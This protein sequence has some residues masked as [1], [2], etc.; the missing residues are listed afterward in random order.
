M[1][2]KQPFCPHYGSNQVVTVAAGAAS[3]VTLHR[4]NKQVRI[5]NTGANKGY[6]RIYTTGDSNS[7]ATAADCPL[8]PGGAIT[9]TKGDQDQIS[10]FS[11][12]G[13]TFEVMT[14]EGF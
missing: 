5:A 7:A 12:G 2:I 3:S 10:C 13:T 1:T 9:V 11:A 14:G 4:G 8:G 6:F